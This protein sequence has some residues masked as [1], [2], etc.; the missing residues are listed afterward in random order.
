MISP[1]VFLVKKCFS[2]S[3]INAKQKF[4]GVPPSHVWFL[5]KKSRN[6]E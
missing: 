3:S 2:I 4:W 6:E 1:T 5:G